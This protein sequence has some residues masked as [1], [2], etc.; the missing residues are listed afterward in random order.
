MGLSWVVYDVYVNVSK[1]CDAMERKCC[2]EEDGEGQS[3]I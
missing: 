1:L 3:D 2:V